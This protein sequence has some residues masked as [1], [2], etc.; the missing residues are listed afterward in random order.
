MSLLTPTENSFTT[1]GH[2]HGNKKCC[3]RK[4]K[5]LGQQFHNFLTT[6][7]VKCFY[8]IFQYNSLTKL[9]SCGCVQIFFSCLDSH[10][11]HPNQSNYVPTS[12]SK[13]NC[14]TMAFEKVECLKIESR[15]GENKRHQNYKNLHEKGPRIRPSQHWTS[16]LLIRLNHLPGSHP[17]MSSS[18]TSINR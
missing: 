2:T 9:C 18:T 7:D 3:T 8:N 11:E 12:H 14:L 13:I 15:C 16:C 17:N 5:F 1:F 6:A 10:I 4:K